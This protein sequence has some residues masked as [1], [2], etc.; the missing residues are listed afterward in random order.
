MFEMEQAGFDPR[1]DAM[2]EILEAKAEIDLASLTEDEQLLFKSLQTAMIAYAYIVVS[3]AALQNMRTDN[4]SKFCNALGTSM[5][6]SAVDCGL[7]DSIEAART[8]LLSRTQWME[9]ASTSTALNMDKPGSGDLLEHF[10]V[11]SVEVSKARP[12][13]GFIRA[14]LTGFDVVAVPLVQE[15]LKSIVGATLQYK[16]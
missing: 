1:F 3:N 11:R 8:T 4:A 10:I 12:R 9:S 6:K 16:W 5:Q 13:Y 15:T 2:T 14:G 7:F